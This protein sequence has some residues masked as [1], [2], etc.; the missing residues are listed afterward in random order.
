MA[1]AD[2][3]Y[4]LLNETDADVC[5]FYND[6]VILTFADA[7]F[8]LVIGQGVAIVCCMVIFS[9]Y[10]TLPSL[11]TQPNSLFALKSIADFC[12]A[13]VVALPA[14]HALL[15][16]SSA[17][18]NASSTTTESGA[19]VERHIRVSSC[20]CQESLAIGAISQFC[21]IASELTLLA[22]AVDLVV[23]LKSP[24]TKFTTNNHI[25]RTV[26]AITAL[27]SVIVYCLVPADMTGEWIFG[28]C[29]YT[30]RLTGESFNWAMWFNF[31]GPILV[32]HAIIIFLLVYACVLGNKNR[33]GHS[34]KTFAARRKVFL[35][36]FQYCVMNTVIWIIF[37]PGYAYL[38]FHIQD[39][40]DETANATNEAAQVAS[41]ASIVSD[42]VALT[43]A[44]GLSVL[45]GLRSVPGVIVWLV[46]G[47]CQMI[48]GVARK[49]GEIGGIEEERYKLS[50]QMN[51]ALREEIVM[52]VE[53]G[54]QELYESSKTAG[55]KANELRQINLLGLNSIQWAKRDALGSHKGR[56]AATVP[57]N[58]KAAQNVADQND[59]AQNDEGVFVVRPVFKDD[60]RHASATLTEFYAKQ[61]SK[62]RRQFFGPSGQQTYADSL[63]HLQA[64]KQTGGRS[65]SFLFFSADEKFVVKTMSKS[66]FISM[67]HMMGFHTTVRN[68]V[69]HMEANP[70]SIICKIVGCY[71]LRL[72]KYGHT[73]YFLVM[74][75]VLPPKGWVHEMY[76]LK[77]STVR[78]SAKPEKD[79]TRAVCKYCNQ[80][81]V[82]GLAGQ[83]PCTYYREHEPVQLLMDNDLRFR[84]IVK[85]QQANT[86]KAQ[87]AKD[88]N[89]LRSMNIMDYSLL[90][91]VRRKRYPLQTVTPVIQFCYE[92]AEDDDELKGSRT[93][94]K[95]L[96]DYVE[97]RRR[98][99][100]A[101]RTDMV[102]SPAPGCEL[103][104]SSSQRNPDTTTPTSGANNADEDGETKSDAVL[105]T[106]SA[107]SEQE[108]SYANQ[109]GLSAYVIEGPS[110]FYL[111]IID[112]FQNWNLAK[113]V[114][115]CAKRTFQCTGMGISAVDP[116]LY[117]DRFVKFCCEKVI[118]SLDGHVEVQ[119]QATDS[120]MLLDTKGKAFPTQLHKF[121]SILNERFENVHAAA[122]NS[123]PDFSTAS[124]SSGFGSQSVLL[125]TTRAP[126]RPAR[127]EKEKRAVAQDDVFSMTLSPAVFT[128]LVKNA[129]FRDA[130]IIITK[131]GEATIESTRAH[132]EQLT[133]TA[134]LFETG[135]TNETLFDESPRS[136]SSSRSPSR[137]ASFAGD[138]PLTPRRTSSLS[139]RRR[140]QRGGSFAD[141]KSFEDRYADLKTIQLRKLMFENG[142]LDP[143]DEGAVQS[144]TREQMINA[145]E[146]FH[147]RGIPTLDSSSVSLQI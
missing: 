137:G 62:L 63:T 40:G 49:D 134:K 126:I 50:P 1:A 60:V 109:D 113:K 20:L 69:Q 91:G 90:V 114:E 108:H 65:E 93:V 67:Q 129:D 34:Q 117:C 19:D 140:F 32:V 141:G 138:I 54:V 73:I 37:W 2:W 92:D 42:R 39:M 146:A 131:D 7:D 89:W 116:E 18:Q 105:P 133:K 25:Y 82:V 15:Y 139:P 130:K 6:I 44:Q 48:R 147:Q 11:R 119:S 24:F 8:L 38:Y 124:A 72:H 120:Q 88:A 33:V 36:S 66:D 13:V 79:G 74:V 31:L 107:S 100:E 87:V 30:F 46:N 4:S 96:C 97:Q 104:V 14:L 3:N 135:A 76:D 103:D 80:T 125:D 43:L 132:L 112:I 45:L 84:L 5:S 94:S 9:S 81:Y 127:K 28:F 83:K 55:S 23:N 128:L 35:M 17:T 118:E 121:T 86:L 144:M 111:G 102:V 64:A 12:F 22:V 98:R 41:V 95:A 16:E 58:S 52:Y 53:A 122:M 78:R 101:G 71:S 68:Y 142:L 115:H 106:P 99:S 143:E 77:G 21:I 75:N 47:Y 10:I 85:P 59:D 61:F 56:G 51:S 27:L 57:S 29:L 110:T 136:R 70:E 145:I 26:I 123:A